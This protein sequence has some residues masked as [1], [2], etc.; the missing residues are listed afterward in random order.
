MGEPLATDDG[1]DTEMGT[2]MTKVDLNER[3]GAWT[4]AGLVTDE[5]AE[6]IASFERRREQAGGRTSLV[7]EALGYV[8]ATLAIVAAGMFVAD[9]WDQLASWSQ[10]LLVGT[11]AVLTFAAGWLIR[12]KEAPAVQRLVSLLWAVTVAAVAFLGGLLAVETLGLED[13]AVALT[14]GL[15]VIVVALP[16]YLL[17]ARPLQQIA[18]AAGVLATAT[19]LLGIPDAAVE[20]FWF[21]LVIWGG[22]LAWVLLAWSEILRPQ[23]TAL[24]LGMLAL[25]LGGQVMA[26]EDLRLLGLVIALV[27]V[28]GVV[29]ASI[30][31]RR[32]LLLAFGAAGV[33]V[34]VPQLVL[35][36][37]AD[38]VG[39]P[40]ALFVIGL[41]L[42]IAAIG[43]AR[44]KSEV[45]DAPFDHEPTDEDDDR[46]ANT[47]VREREE[48]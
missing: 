39:A 1:D 31:T 2:S 20:P 16:L 44:I 32:T 15:A 6:A 47:A 24:V 42:V 23:S 19:S 7:A 38:T 18:L 43:L 4:S 5:Q 9:Y 36:L 27:T 37:F 29:L 35:E 26:S 48:V 34:F 41:V 13:A 40:L 12:D 22:G 8:G 10:Q 3:L 33:F 11:V 14:V 45:I 28:A 46:F 21:G 17:R 25:G 30:A